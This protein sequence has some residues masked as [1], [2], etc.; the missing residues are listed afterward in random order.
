MSDKDEKELEPGVYESPFDDYPGFIRFPH[1]LMYAPH[2]QEYWALVIEPAKGL[3]LLDWDSHHLPWLGAKYL[4]TQY[5]EVSIK[6]ISKG[7]LDEDRL[8]LNVQQWVIKCAKEYLAPEL[9]P[10]AS[11]VVLTLI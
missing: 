5:G 10:K 9:G 1:P 3:T 11:P 2:L 4:L 8:P 7:D 6:D